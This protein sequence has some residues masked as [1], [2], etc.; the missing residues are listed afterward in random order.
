MSHHHA[1]AQVAEPAVVVVEDD[2]TMRE[3]LREAVAASGCAC[4][5]FSDCAGALAYLASVQEPPDLVLSDLVMPGM[6]GMDLLRTVRAISPDLP[7][8]LV[9]GLCEL[10]NAM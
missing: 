1:A 2:A 9:S 8:I 5:T 4:Q 10:S 6:S 7:F 3:Y